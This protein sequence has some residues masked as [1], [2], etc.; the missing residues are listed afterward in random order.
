MLKWIHLSI[1]AVLFAMIVRKEVGIRVGNAGSIFSKMRKVWYS[2]GISLNTK[3]KLFNG[4][5]V[6]ILMHSSDETWEGLKDVENILRVFERNRLRK[7][8]NIKWYEHIAE[9]EVGTCR[10]AVGSRI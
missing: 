9:E 2:R 10:Q 1:W 6:P 7:I 3:V 5:V 4:T 8:M